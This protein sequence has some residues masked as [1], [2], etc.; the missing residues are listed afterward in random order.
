MLLTLVIERVHN[1]FFC[2]LVSFSAEGHF[3]CFPAAYEVIL[4]IN[5]HICEH[6]SNST[7]YCVASANFSSPPFIAVHLKERQLCT[8]SSVTELDSAPWDL[9]FLFFPTQ[10]TLLSALLLLSSSFSLIEKVLNTLLIPILNKSNVSRRHRCC[11][12]ETPQGLA[13]A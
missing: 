12:S 13:F 7:S 11:S 9:M 10:Y 1:V 3:Y 2:M 5:F 8:S 4:G 6:D